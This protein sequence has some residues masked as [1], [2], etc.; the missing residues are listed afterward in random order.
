MCTVVYPW[1]LLWRMPFLRST[2][3]PPII[4]WTLSIIPTYHVW[5]PRTL[6]HPW[7]LPGWIVVREYGSVAASAISP[8]SGSHDHRATMLNGQGRVT[9]TVPHAI[10]CIQERLQVIQHDVRSLT[11]E[12]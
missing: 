5:H 7:V 8:C 9:P 4:V 10:F 1:Y 6:G 3:T 2:S 12:D 11:E